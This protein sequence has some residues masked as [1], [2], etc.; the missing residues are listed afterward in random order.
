MCTESELKQKFIHEE[1]DKNND[2]NNNISA[3]FCNCRITATLY[4]VKICFVSVT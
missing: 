1:E 3:L 4:I 2:D